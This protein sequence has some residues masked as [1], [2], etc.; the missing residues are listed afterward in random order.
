HPGLAVPAEGVEEAAGRGCLADDLAL[1]IQAGGVAGLPS[2]QGAQVRDR[3]GQQAAILK[4]FKGQRPPL[5]PALGS[6]HRT[7]SRNGV[8]QMNRVPQPVSMA[9]CTGKS[10]EKIAL[11]GRIG[12]MLSA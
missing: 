9:A 7:S 6:C 12:R 4:P 1:V 11:A 2:V 8:G 10:K 3:V 5:T